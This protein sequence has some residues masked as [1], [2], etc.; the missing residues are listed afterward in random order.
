MKE[1]SFFKLIAKSMSFGLIPILVIVV[2]SVLI[3]FLNP[4]LL[5][6]LPF[7]GVPLLIVIVPI[8]A[9]GYAIRKGSGRQRFTGP[10]AVGLI[11]FIG[12]FWIFPTS[13]LWRK[14]F[15]RKLFEEATL[16][17]CAKI[18]EVHKQ[19]CYHMVGKK[20]GN[21]KICELE[22][23]EE[24]RVCYKANYHLITDADLCSPIDLIIYPGLDGLSV[25]AIECFGRSNKNKAWEE[26][27]RRIS[28][29]S[30]ES[31]ILN[32]KKAQCPTP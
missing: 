5:V 28:R 27:C 22:N 3:A 10:L 30:E 32:S 20:S 26:A 21:P 13:V 29:F 7:V 14:Y 9:M 24:S 25:S 2:I 1:K 12:S 4:G 8:L 18:S 23:K 31:R 6:F 16:E 15:D 17:S 11:L 19:Q